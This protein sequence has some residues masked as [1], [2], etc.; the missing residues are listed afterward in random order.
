MFGVDGVGDG[1]PV[2]W[3]NEVE[4]KVVHWIFRTNEGQVDDLQGPCSSLG[5]E[6]GGPNF[7]QVLTRFPPFRLAS[8]SSDR[9]NVICTS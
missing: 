6:G 5:G 9:F 2:K 7:L 3:R 8:L 1:G 4:M